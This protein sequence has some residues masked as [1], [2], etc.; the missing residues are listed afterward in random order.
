MACGRDAGKWMFKND[1]FQVINNAIDMD[2]LQFSIHTRNDIRNKYEIGNDCIVFGHVGRFEY[3]KNHE[4]LIDIFYEY[5]K[6][7]GNSCLLLL[8]SGSLFEKIQNKVCK[9]GIQDKVKFVGVVDNACDFYQAMDVFV[10]PSFYEGLPFCLVEAQASGL[11]C[12]VSDKV[13]NE[14]YITPNV[15]ELSVD[16]PARVWA[17]AVKINV[18]REDSIQEIC[19]MYENACYTTEATAKQLLNIYRI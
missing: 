17:E 2:K 6:I 11:P 19:E 7:N 14:S 4:F 5:Q 10:L 15:I 18:K 13:T 8:G 9:L 3:A 16:L 1:K 12:L